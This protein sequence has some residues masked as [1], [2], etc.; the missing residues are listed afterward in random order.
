MVHP[1]EED[2]RALVQ[3]VANEIYDPCG[4]AQG[5][6]IGL[7]DMGLLRTIEVR[8]IEGGWHVDLRLRL[9]TPGCFYFV[10]FER[11]IRGRLQAFPF[12]TSLHIEWD[13]VFDWT[14]EDLSPSAQAK[15]ASIRETLLMRGVE[16][17]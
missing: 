10:Y 8:R 3:A 6:S 14:P 17:R 9:T 2:I 1:R 13:D 7:V 4:L 11:E 12:I 5:V 16:R 15:L